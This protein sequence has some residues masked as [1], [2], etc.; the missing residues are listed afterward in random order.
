MN[1]II[2][3]CALFAVA[4]ADF[5]VKKQEDLQK[6][7]GECVKELNITAEEIEEYKKWNFTESGNTPCYLKCVF[8]KMEL[9]DDEKEFL[10]R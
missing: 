1:K 5:V 6:F 2:I 10:V 7:R 3:A 4:S 9:F 8:I